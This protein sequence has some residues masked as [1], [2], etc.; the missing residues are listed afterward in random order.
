LLIFVTMNKNAN[1]KSLS[2]TLFMASIA[3]AACSK[4]PAAPPCPGSFKELAKPGDE[5]ACTC[6]ASNTRGSV[7]GVDTYTTDSALCAAAVHAGAIP[8]SGGEIRVKSS[9]G[10]N[11]Y[12]G[13]S[14]NGI[15]SG[16]WGSFPGSYYFVGKGDG[17]CHEAAAAAAPPPPPPKP[18][19]SCPNTFKDISGANASTELTCE[20]KAVTPATVWG[21]SV[22]TQ[23]S[24]ICSAAVHA[25]AVAPSGGQV[26]VKA[27]PGCA[28]YVGSAQNG[29]TTQ[30]WGSFAGSFYFP[31]KADGRCST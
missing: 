18:V 1:L 25:G 27:A 7:W 22:Y 9:P 2:V 11:S 8:A 14:R 28:K 16:S 23:D 6:A 20:C 13:S 4:T 17:T 5:T 24:S 19:A 12:Q 3:L 10:C 15:T 30:S 29:V 26:S 21:T 31:T